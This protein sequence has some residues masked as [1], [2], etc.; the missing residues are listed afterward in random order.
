MTGRSWRARLAATWG[1]RRAERQIDEELASHL[2]LAADEFE[3][4]G[5]GREEARREAMLQLGGLEQTRESLRDG[6]GLPWLENFGRDARLAM[7][8]FRKNPGLALAVT[9]MMALSIGATASLYSVVSAMILHPLN[10]PG[11]GRLV[12]LKEQRSG[13]DLSRFVGIR[14]LRELQR[15]ESTME[16]AGMMGRDANVSG[17]GLEAERVMCVATQSSL[18]RVLRA[19][20]QAGRLLTERDDQSGAER[21]VVAS[22][23]YWRSRL[24]GRPD[25]VGRQLM[26]DGLP[27]TLVGVL[28]ASFRL[29]GLEVT[30][31]EIYVSGLLDESRWKPPLVIAV[32]VARLKDGATP[33]QAQAEFQAVAN[34]HP[35]R[36]GGA[37]RIGIE[38]W[39]EDL[40]RDARPPLSLLSA[41]A[42][43]LLLVACVN[44]ANL[45]LAR[46][47]QRQREFAVRRALGA[48]SRRIVSQLLVESVLLALAGAFCGWV[49]AYAGKDLL[50]G[51]LSQRLPEMPPVEMDLA[52]LWVALATGVFAGLLF[53][54][55]PA[56]NAV[57][58]DLNEPLKEGSRSSGSRAVRRFRNMLVAAEVG[59]SLAGMV[60][61]G[62][63]LRSL[64]KLEAVD[65]GFRTRNV[66]VGTVDLDRYRYATSERQSEFAAKVLEEVRRIPGVEAAGVSSHIPLGGL[67]WSMS[68]IELEGRAKPIPMT[69][70]GVA[71][72]S[73]FDTIGIPLREGRG[74]G[75]SDVRGA[76]EVAVVDGR[77]AELYCPE[78]G[79]IGLRF[80]HWS[81]DGRMVR[82]VGLV[83]EVRLS[84]SSERQP[85]LYRPLAQEGMFH[86][87]FLARSSR[88]DLRKRM[89][90]AARRADPGQPMHGLEPLEARR[91]KSLAPKRVMLALVGI[92]GLLALALGA[93]GVASVLWHEVSQEKRAIGIR[94]ALGADAARI[95]RREMMR[96]MST[97]VAGALAGSIWGWLLAGWMKSELWGIRTDD[98]GA[99][100]AAWLTVLAAGAA[101]CALPAWMG[102]RVEVARVLRTE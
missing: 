80:R 92:L 45:Q 57:R 7:R 32:A 27:H 60:A 1:K 16:S 49:L 13:L 78:R 89:A 55:W 84:P 22:H 53:G 101:A 24:G 20:A 43:I 41:V 58:L 96:G 46:G 2:A 100:L 61:S 37:S 93:M 52:V 28:P 12:I 33:E 44:A 5:L 97:V 11:A 95:L 36:R 87:E 94:M 68:D 10:Y 98:A 71:T 64:L 51:Y 14:L 31:T 30:R 18:F 21:V 9:A 75:A 72:A 74:F 81:D 91:A 15:G 3:R 56:C 102:S 29:A 99:W 8:N 59:L 35:S 23:A 48:G 42:A 67:V 66:I 85:T 54:L 39:E 19:N 76:E 17:D 50:T 25:A 34:A 38:Y 26:V 82:I 63:L 65:G 79:C 6:I 4:Q 69:E 86:L 70:V 90:E 47:L 73:Y 62:L 40:A 77:F 88:Q 83:G